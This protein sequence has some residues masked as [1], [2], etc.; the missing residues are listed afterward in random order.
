[1]GSASAIHQV[2]GGGG[3]WETGGGGALFSLNILAQ[4]VD[5]GYCEA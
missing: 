3:G 1:M 2:S 5:E 4:T